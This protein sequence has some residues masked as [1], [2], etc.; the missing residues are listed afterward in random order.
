MLAGLGAYFLNFLAGK[1]KNSKLAQA[2]LAAHKQ[3]LE[4]NFSI[5]GKLLGEN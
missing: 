1:T 2:W 3:L 4:E 5:V